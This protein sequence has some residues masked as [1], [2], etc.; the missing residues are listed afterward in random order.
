MQRKA[1]QTTA[2]TLLLDFL[3][4][5]VSISDNIEY[6]PNMADLILLAWTDDTYENKINTISS[7]YIGRIYRNYRIKINY[8]DNQKKEYGFSDYQFTQ[9]GNPMQSYSNNII[10]FS[11]PPA[12]LI[13]ETSELE[14][15]D[16]KTS[17]L[18]PTYSD[19][20]INVS[21]EI[22][23]IPKIP[24]YYHFF[25]ETH[26]PKYFIL[27]GERFAQNTPTNTLDTQTTNNIQPSRPQQEEPDPTRPEVI[28]QGQVPTPGG[29][30]DPT[31]VYN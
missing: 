2:K 21:L 28:E 16:I 14:D 10:S 15:Q 19:A 25:Y 13:E 3:S 17:V 29:Y 7:N 26:T 11:S 8:P 18:I 6:Q 20:L 22:Y 4:I 24:L 23:T 12:S 27:A 1:G 5:P 9:T 31:I 30:E